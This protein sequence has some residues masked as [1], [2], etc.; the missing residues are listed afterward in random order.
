[1]LKKD[2]EKRCFEIGV[3]S[4]KFHTFLVNKNEPNKTDKLQSGLACLLTMCHKGGYRGGR[5]GGHPPPLGP[6]KCCR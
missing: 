2:Q 3:L 4:A 6:I 1:M 5:V